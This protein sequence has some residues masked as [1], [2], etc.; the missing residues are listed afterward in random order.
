[1]EKWFTATTHSPRFLQNLTNEESFSQFA[2]K[3]TSELH[4]QRNYVPADSGATRISAASQEAADI[5]LQVE[6]MHNQYTN[7]S[8]RDQILHQFKGMQ[9]QHT[10]LQVAGPQTT[11]AE[12][13]RREQN[14]HNQ[15]G[16]EPNPNQEFLVQT[17][18]ITTLKQNYQDTRESEY[19]PKAP[20]RNLAVESAEIANSQ[21]KL[22]TAAVQIATHPQ[23]RQPHELINSSEKSAPLQ[24][25]DNT[26]AQIKD[27]FEQGTTT[28][29]TS[30]EGH[31]S[32]NTAAAHNHIAHNIAESHLQR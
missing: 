1:L 16:P 26:T 30:K 27:H 32:K 24:N 5:E 2:Q 14:L 29:Q 25:E 19:L 31:L 11:S 9:T 22:H 4:L 6:I 10:T 13:Q 12:V 20:N 3:L 28:K 18:T 8:G 17:H 23:Q 21:K 15:I 7:Q